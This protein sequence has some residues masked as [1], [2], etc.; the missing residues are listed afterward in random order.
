MSGNR[1]GFDPE[2]HVALQASDSLL[3]ALTTDGPRTVV[4]TKLIEALVAWRASVESEPL[5]NP[6]RVPAVVYG[7]RRRRMADWFANLAR[8][9]RLRLGCR[10]TDHE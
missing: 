1:N 10:R 3:N 2:N 8:R 4:E 6:L 9:L 7:W 5:P